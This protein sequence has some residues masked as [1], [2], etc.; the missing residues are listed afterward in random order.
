MS[1][2]ASPLLLAAS[3]MLT[4]C[5]SDDG[6]YPSL[7]KRPAE[8][9]TG[10]WPPP[11]PPP[12]PAPPPLGAATLDRLDRLVADA[13]SA[14]TRFYSKESLARRLVAA[15]RGAPIGSERWVVATMAVSDLES[16]R[17]QA[18]LAMAE[19]DS[20]YA[21]ARTEGRDVAPI[22]TARNQVLA[23]IAGQD[24]T[25]DSLNGPLER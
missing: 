7:A 22:E 23:I 2:L 15:A 16:S 8:R 12:L 20:L 21:E 4:A 17:A 10:T 14:D 3:L 18:L 25:L 1:R 13:R 19:L 24:R 5:A 9:I 11:P 6:I